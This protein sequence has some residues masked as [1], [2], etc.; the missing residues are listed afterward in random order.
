MDI[1][2]WWYAVEPY[3]GESLSHYLGRFRRE[4]GLSVNALGRE[5]E[6]G[7]VVI[8]RWERFYFNPPPTPEQIQRLAAHLG[9]TA[10]QVRAMLPAAPL[11]LEPIRLC[12]A[13][14]AEA[15][16]HRL[17]WQYKATTVCLVHGVR[18]LSECPR[19][20]K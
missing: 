2:P 16:Y 12:A 7:G 3:P 6:L 8:G 17:V 14:Y 1:Q 5:T 10:V 11:K 15:P 4:N 9:L 13:C 18:L 19:C 20:K